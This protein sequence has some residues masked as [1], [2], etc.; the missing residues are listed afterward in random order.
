MSRKH[1]HR[2]AVFGGACM[3]AA[4]TGTALAGTASAADIAD[5]SEGSQCPAGLGELTPDA[6]ARA[7]DTALGGLATQFPNRDVSDAYVS[8]ATRSDAGPVGQE[9]IEECGPGVQGKAVIVDFV[10]PAMLPDAESAYG[11]A[12]VSPING[13]YTVWRTA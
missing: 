7:T 12:V 11:A 5:A 6:V 1:F 2:A 4:A 8:G 13:Q 10:F 9:L 3:L